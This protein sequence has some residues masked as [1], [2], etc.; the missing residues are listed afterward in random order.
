MAGKWW[1]VRVRLEAESPSDAALRLRRVGALPQNI[2][3]VDDDAGYIIE[4]IVEAV[5][6]WKPAGTAPK[7]GQP[8][9]A[10]DPGIGFAETARWHQESKKFLNFIGDKEALFSMWM[11]QPPGSSQAQ[12]LQSPPLY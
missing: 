3:E 4:T 8:F 11:E 1:F 2:E 5:S 10:F 12:T 7:S 6:P 9:V